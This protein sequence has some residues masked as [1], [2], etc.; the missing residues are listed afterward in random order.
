MKER[1]KKEFWICD[2]M[3][4][5]LILT[6]SDSHEEAERIADQLLEQ[7]LAAAVQIVGPVHSRYR[8]QE[9][10]HQKQ[11]WVLLIK[12]SESREGEI[13]AVIKKLHSYELPA[14]LKL[15][16][17]GGESQYLQWILSQSS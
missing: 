6:N 7:R 8:W 11:E 17:A 9:T 4:P 5:V 14:I 2:G 3:N 13:Q 1:G 15:N 12:T 16:I 10:I